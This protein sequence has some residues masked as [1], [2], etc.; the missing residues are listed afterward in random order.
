MKTFPGL[1]GTELLRVISPWVLTKC[2]TIRVN[3]MKEEFEPD[4]QGDA[5]DK[6]PLQIWLCLVETWQQTI[7][8]CPDTSGVDHSD[9]RCWCSLEL[10]GAW[11]LF[12]PKKNTMHSCPVR[13]YH[14]N[15]IRST[16]VFPRENLSISPLEMDDTFVRTPSVLM[17]G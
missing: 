6:D 11:L 3:F 4:Y 16:Q 7:S 1:D 17:F 13:L 8:P 9:E 2:N 5:M 15:L 10:A 14:R 12:S